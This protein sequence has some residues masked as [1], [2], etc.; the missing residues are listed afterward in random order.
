MF[1]NNNPKQ[2]RGVTL[3]EPIMVSEIRLA[4]ELGREHMLFDF[5]KEKQKQ[6]EAMQISF[7]ILLATDIDQQEDEDRSCMIRTCHF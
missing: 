4:R 1:E 6:C 5:P 7:E 2:T 3:R